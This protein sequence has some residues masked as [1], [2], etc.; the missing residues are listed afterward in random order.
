MDKEEKPE[1]YQ[2]FAQTTTSRRFSIKAA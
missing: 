1:I 2:D